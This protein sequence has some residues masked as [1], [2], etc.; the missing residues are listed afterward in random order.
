MA[1]QRRGSNVSS[2]SSLAVNDQVSY[3]TV[4]LDN[5]AKR[6]ALPIRNLEACMIISQKSSF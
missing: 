3:V 1:R 6:L 5:S 4:L 2:S